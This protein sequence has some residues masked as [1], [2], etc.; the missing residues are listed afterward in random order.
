MAADSS[1][2]RC[3]GRRAIAKGTGVDAFFGFLKI[4]VICGT[5]LAVLLVVLLSLPRS[6]LRDFVLS[7][8]Q[9]VGAT[10]VGAGVMMPDL[11]IPVFGELADVAV[12]AFL[13]FYWW[14]F[15]RNLQRRAQAQ[16]LADS[17]RLSGGPTYLTDDTDRHRR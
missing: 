7:L 5:C 4:V 12:I 1:R 15:F 13:I 3:A 11:T 6:P 17:S 9:R 16:A 10:V 14:T 8:T 2:S